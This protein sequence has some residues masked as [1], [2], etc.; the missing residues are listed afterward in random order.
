MSSSST[1]V[2]IPLVFGAAWC[3]HRSFVSPQ[4]PATTDER[5]AGKK[6]F[7]RVFAPIIPLVA[8]VM[9]Y[10]TWI[11]A[12]AESAAILANSG[13]LPAEIQQRLLPLLRIDYP[14]LIGRTLPATL[15]VGSGIMFFGTWFR[16]QA[17]KTIGRNFS[18]EVAMKKDHSLVTDGP[19][20]AVRH[21][22]YTGLVLNWVGMG[23]VFATADGW[24]R[25]S[26]LPWITEQPASTVAKVGA[27]T[28]AALAVWSHAM[29]VV[30]VFT[31][32]HQED[33][34]LHKRFGKQWEDWSL[35]TPYRLIPYIY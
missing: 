21:P 7:E 34:L 1:L 12:I 24:V 15:V 4:A 18:F 25:Q 30:A 3:V 6:G 10:A 13:L 17:F 22:S 5:Q 35:R 31:R 14:S 19:Y 33:S 27:T 8:P 26:L 2:R 9:R 32:L 23:L 20:S 11:P 16:I 28:F 29:T